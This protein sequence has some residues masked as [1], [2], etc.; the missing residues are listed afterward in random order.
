MRYGR[1]KA[2]GALADFCERV[3][4]REIAVDGDRQVLVIAYFAG[5]RKEWD[6]PVGRVSVQGICMYVAE[7]GSGV[8]RI[9]DQL[10]GDQFWEKK[11]E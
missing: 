8:A 10:G 11:N 7:T 9:Q 2:V 5:T 1:R 6:S 3:S 4:E